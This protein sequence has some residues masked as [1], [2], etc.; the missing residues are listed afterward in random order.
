MQGRQVGREV[1]GE[2]RRRKGEILG[3]WRLEWGVARGRWWRVRSG[4]NDDVRFSNRVVELTEFYN[5]AYS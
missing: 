4:L 2:G 3:I 5:T 1:V